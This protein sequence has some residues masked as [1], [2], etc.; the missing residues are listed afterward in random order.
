LPPALAKR[1]TV[2]PRADQERDIRYHM[3]MGLY[4]VGNMG[5]ARKE[6]EL[7]VSGNM[8]FAQADEGRALLKQSSDA[9][10]NWPSIPAAHADAPSPRAYPASGA[11]PAGSFAE[12]LQHGPLIAAAMR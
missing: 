8:R 10:L 2:T 6:L 3:A 5:T 4:K 9:G 11:I 7:L 1:A 12:A